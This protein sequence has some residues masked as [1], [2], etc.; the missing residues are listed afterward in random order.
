MVAYQ[1][2]LDRARSLALN[3]RRIRRSARSRLARA[4][5]MKRAR[6][7]QCRPAKGIDRE[8]PRAAARLDADAEEETIMRLGPDLPVQLKRKIDIMNAHWRDYDRSYRAQSV[9]PADPR[10]KPRAHS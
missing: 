1:A 9:T 5:M 4:D 8:H 2:H 3:R 7:R 6:N 10:N